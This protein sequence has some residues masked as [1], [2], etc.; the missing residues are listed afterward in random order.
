MAD[1]GWRTINGTHVYLSGR[2][3]IMRGPSALVGKKASELNSPNGKLIYAQKSISLMS[4]KA[5]YKKMKKEVKEKEIKERKDKKF[6]EKLNKIAEEGKKTPKQPTGFVHR[7]S[8][9]VTN[10]KNFNGYD[11]PEELFNKNGDLNS[12]GKKVFLEKVKED[13]TKA[14][15]VSSIKS[16]FQ[17]DFKKAGITD[18]YVKSDIATFMK[19]GHSFDQ[20]VKMALDIDSKFKA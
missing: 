4:A 2:G 3:T 18:N 16:A 5:D 15:Q 1:I 17:D 14:I 11:I 12:K 6:K 8:N 20:A 19:Q 10:T 7:V 9:P 13:P